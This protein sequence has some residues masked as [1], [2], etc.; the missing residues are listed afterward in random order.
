LTLVVSDRRNLDKQG[1][2]EKIDDKKSATDLA[3]A[4]N[5]GTRIIISTQQKFSFILDI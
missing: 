5:K 2:V 4:L 1:V 3:K